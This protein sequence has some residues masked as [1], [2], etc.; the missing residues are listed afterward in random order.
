MK[1][2]AS[3]ALCIALLPACSSSSDPQAAGSEH[4]VDLA[5]LPVE[6]PVDVE[7]LGHA[8]Q[9]EYGC[10][11]GLDTAGP[12]VIYR[13]DVPEAGLLAVDVAEGAG[14]FLLASS[15]PASCLAG[16]TNRVAIYLEPSTVYLAVEAGSAVAPT[17]AVALTSPSW[18]AEQGMSE[19]VARSGLR[20]FSKSWAA[21]DTTRLEYALGDFS[22]SSVERREWIVDLRKRELLWNLH[23][24]HGWGSADPDDPA[25]AV[26]F[27]DTPESHMSSLGMIRTAEAYV[28][29]YGTSHRL[30]GLEP[31]FNANVRPRDIVV[32]P[33][34]ES[35]PE[36]VAA[37]AMTGPTW[38]CP[39]IDDRVAPDVVARM[40]GGA[41]MW[42][43]FPDPEWIAAS[44]YLK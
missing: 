33:W 13:V 15:D 34:E 19:E 20:A 27:S 36:Y 23:V 16:G 9:A 42:F 7:T 8:E 10:A 30:D 38:G 12:E 41:L 25:K 32:H 26:I 1:L 24:A 28:G 35:R 44:T 37:N 43:W 3:I 14:V 2:L 11:S 18:L 5:S 40:S 29:D 17:L 22:L 21:G 6:E 39:G 31:G 4:V